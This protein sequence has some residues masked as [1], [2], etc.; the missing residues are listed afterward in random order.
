LQ[1][2]APQELLAAKAEIIKLGNSGN[3]YYTGPMYFGT[4][5]QGINSSFIYDTSSDY[6]L[7]SSTWC[8]NCNTTYFDPD[9]STTFSNSTDDDTT[10]L[11]YN[12]EDELYEGYMGVDRV[13]LSKNTTYS[14]CAK[15]FMFFVITN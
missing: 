14:S 2:L 11:N 10:Y 13:C 7:T 9:L 12:N 3:T 8:S 1:G 15:G 5:L 6:T 4:P